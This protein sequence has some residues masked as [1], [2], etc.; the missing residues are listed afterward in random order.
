[1]QRKQKH[2]W[3]ARL[4][5]LGLLAGGLAQ[6]AWMLVDDFSSGL[7]NWTVSAS[8]NGIVDTLTNPLATGPSGNTVARLDM[9]SQT[10]NKAAFMTSTS[11]YS[12]GTAAALKV[13]FDLGY[14]HA[15]TNQYNGW[16]QYLSLAATPA[17]TTDSYL[18]GHLG[19]AGGADQYKFQ[20]HVDGGD[21][22]SSPDAHQYDG[23][24]YHYEL[25]LT[26]SQTTLNVYAWT[27]SNPADYLA[28]TPVWTNT[29]N[30]GIGSGN[31]YLRLVNLKPSLDTNAQSRDIMY[32]DNVYYSV[33]EPA[34]LALLA[35]GGLALFRRRR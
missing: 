15:P 34:S 13:A 1:M 12:R 4:T 28:A 2:D 10:A 30:T 6:A 33:P 35:L 5:V 9:S 23:T 26:A 7:G 16:S 32:A 27:S 22:P 8:G 29:I 25:S 11:T 31:Y 18:A 20:M 24:W 21:W 3:L 14:T 19:G 17:A